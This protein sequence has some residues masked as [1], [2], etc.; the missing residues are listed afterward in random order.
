MACWLTATRRSL[1]Q[2]HPEFARS[3][4]ST[5]L[6]AGRRGDRIPEDVAARAIESLKKPDDHEEVAVWITRYLTK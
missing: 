2:L 1:L 5:A 4:Y 3:D 6:I